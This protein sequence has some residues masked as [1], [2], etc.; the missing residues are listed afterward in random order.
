MKPRTLSVLIALGLMMAIGPLGL[1]WIARDNLHDRDIIKLTS[2]VSDLPKRRVLAVF[3][4]PDDE[5]TVAGTLL[6]LKESGHEVF[7]VMLTRGEAGGSPEGYGRDELA[8]I[9]TVEM[10]QSAEI[11]QVDSL[12]LL[13]YADGGLKA[14]GLDALESIVNDWIAQ[15]KPDVLISYDSKV[16]LYGHDDHR[17]TGLAVESVFLKRVNQEKVYPTQLFQVTLSPKQIRVALQV[18]EGFEKNYPLDPDRGLPSPDFSVDVQSTFPG[19]LAAM[20]AH[21]S[22]RM[23]L[24]DLMPYHDRI[25]A[26]FYSRIFDR[27]YFY[28]V[29][30]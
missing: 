7:L 11:L 23:V 5:I 2:L 27:E 28:E 18:S 4:H 22:Q 14:L 29:K 3:P 26:M 9:R 25:P 21:Y 6:K 13:N 10:R 12:H 1:V 8:E 17:L 24:Q 30:Q 19:K 20:K 16:G 15:I